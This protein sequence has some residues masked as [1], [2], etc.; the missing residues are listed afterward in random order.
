MS[1]LADCS[2]SEVLLRASIYRKPGADRPADELFGEEILHARHVEPSLRRLWL[3]V[4]VLLELY[5][6]W[7]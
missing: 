6:V 1:L 7:S 3:A 5:S 4:A 2:R